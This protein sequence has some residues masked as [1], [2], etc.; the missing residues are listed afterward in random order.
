MNWGLVLAFVFNAYAFAEKPACEEAYR[1]A[2]LNSMLPIFS[3]QHQMDAIAVY[4]IFFDSSYGLPLALREGEPLF[5][6]LGV[7]AS[8]YVEVLDAFGW[9]MR[10]GRLCDENGDTVSMG[11]AIE[12][13]RAQWNRMH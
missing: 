6:S 11:R 13:L 1:R 4:K 5:R 2:Y 10:T 3:T 7:D 12:I 8:E 9:L